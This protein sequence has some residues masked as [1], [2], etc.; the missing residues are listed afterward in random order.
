[1]TLLLILNI[2]T[3]VHPLR[4]YWTVVLQPL[5]A[6]E[7]EESNIVVSVA[8]LPRVIISAGYLATLARLSFVVPSRTTTT[9]IS[10]AVTVASVSSLYP[11]V[12][13]VSIAG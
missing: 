2:V 8:T 11:I 10:S 6:V 7:M 9:C 5:I 4:S 1:M 3:T 12:R 13:A